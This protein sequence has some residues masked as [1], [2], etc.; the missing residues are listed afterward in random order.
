MSGGTGAY[1]HDDYKRKGY[2]HYEY[3]KDNLQY[4]MLKGPLRRELHRVF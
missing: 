4:E 2:G 3:S 1:D